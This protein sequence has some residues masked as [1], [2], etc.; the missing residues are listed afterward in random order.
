MIAV[1][2]CQQSNSTKDCLF[3]WHCMQQE[4]AV[5]PKPLCAQL[6]LLSSASKLLWLSQ[7]CHTARRWEWFVS[8]SA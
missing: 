8:V 6:V 5:L 4:W 3:G 2:S 1:A 7:R